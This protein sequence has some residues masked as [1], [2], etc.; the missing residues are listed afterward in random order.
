MNT[1]GIDGNFQISYR[2]IE[3]YLEMKVD[4]EIAS[5]I[6]FIIEI[7]TNPFFRKKW[8]SILVSYEIIEI[9]NEQQNLVWIVFT[10]ER[11]QLMDLSLICTTKFEN[12]SATVIFQS[13]EHAKIPI[14]PNHTRVHCEESKYIISNI[15]NPLVTTED[16]QAN[17]NKCLITYTTKMMPDMA[18]FLCSEFVEETGHIKNSWK[19]LKILAEKKDDF[20]GEYVKRM[21]ENIILGALKTKLMF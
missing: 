3:K 5:S 12:D 1:K 10:S 19:N 2:K 18:R 17:N 4:I 7:I 13:I 21:K 16:S 14:D 6:E 8:D 20:D 11:N 15:S 9:F